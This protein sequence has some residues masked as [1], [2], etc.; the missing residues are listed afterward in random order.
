[1]KSRKYARKLMRKGKSPFKSYSRTK[2]LVKLINRVSLKKSETKHTHRIDENASINH[3]GEV[4]KYGFL[5]TQQGVGDPDNGTSN[6]VGR[7]GN[8]VV[9]RGLSFKIWLA[10]K[11]DRPNVMYRIVIFRYRAD[12][13]PT[14]CYKSQG[15]A[16]IMLRDLDTDLF[17]PVK[18]MRININQGAAERIITL[19][20]T[21]AGTEGH[22]YRSVYIPLKN[23][24]IKYKDDNSGSPK[25][26]DYA[27]SISAYDSWGTP[28]TD[29]VG[30]VAT[31][32]KFY[33][34]D[35]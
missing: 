30:S 7:V 12:S 22:A 23:K 32:V 5:Y 6:Y 25:Y 1:M 14:T 10:N 21:F 15:S 13:V 18:T 29:L 9:A 35:P 34:K 11:L 33:W 24:I 26:Y 17:T 31:N 27:Y 28:Q 2:Q 20:D 19:T 4:I 8:E 16:N 3:N